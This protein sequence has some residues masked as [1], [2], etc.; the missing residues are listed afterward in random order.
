MLEARASVMRILASLESGGGFSS[1]LDALSGVEIPAALAAVAADGAPTLLQ[2][3]QSFAGPAR[4]ALAASLRE[5]AGGNAGDRVS[6]FLRTQLGARSLSPREGGDPDAILSRAEAALGAGELQTALDEIATLPESG[7]A[8]MSEWAAL[9]Q[10][11]LDAVEAAATL[12]ATLN[13]N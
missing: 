6:A 3:Q 4:E 12:A 9:V 1:S 13:V 2:L 7:Q 8:A 10:T 11:R 5:T